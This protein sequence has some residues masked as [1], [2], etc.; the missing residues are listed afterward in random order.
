LTLT[1]STKTELRVSIAMSTADHPPN[2]EIG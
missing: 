1:A 2:D